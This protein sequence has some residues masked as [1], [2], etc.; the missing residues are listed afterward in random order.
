ME[1]GNFSN[2]EKLIGALFQKIPAQMLRLKNWIN[3]REPNLF[4]VEKSKLDLGL[5]LRRWVR[6]ET[7][8]GYCGKI[9]LLNI[10][11]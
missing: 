5:D 3:F 9:S 6:R 7:E 10:G 8:L 4:W 1:K 11:I 2:I